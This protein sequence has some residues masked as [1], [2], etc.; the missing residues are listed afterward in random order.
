MCYL[1]ALPSYD[2]NFTSGF[3]IPGSGFGP[4][5]CTKSVH[6]DGNQPTNT[7]PCDV[8]CTGPGS[9]SDHGGTCTIIPVKAGAKPPRAPLLVNISCTNVFTGG[10]TCAGS[11]IVTV[12]DTDQKII[13]TADYGYAR[14]AVPS[15]SPPSASPDTSN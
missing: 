1:V 14:G 12:G 4:C 3:N 7:H 11:V 9:T 5:D 15:M 6:A 2:L 10:P 13:C 8:A